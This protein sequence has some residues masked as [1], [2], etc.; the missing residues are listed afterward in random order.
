MLAH[1]LRRGIR[2][3]RTFYMELARLAVPW[4]AEMWPWPLALDDVSRVRACR[5]VYVACD[6]ANR[7]RY[8]GVVQR[9]DHKALATRVA[10]HWRGRRPN[11]SSVW[12][13]PLRPDTPRR[14]ALDFE[15]MLIRLLQPPENITGIW[16]LH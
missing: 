6:S 8:V 15:M 12:F 5:G 2:L 3:T 10:E 16:V 7:L 14:V 13:I 9:E 1:D 11:W 4:N